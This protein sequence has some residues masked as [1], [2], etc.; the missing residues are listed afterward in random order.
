MRNDL[1]VSKEKKL[2]PGPANYNTNRGGFSSTI[3]SN[4]GLKKMINT[5]E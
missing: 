5:A 1:I 2:G 3:K 4:L